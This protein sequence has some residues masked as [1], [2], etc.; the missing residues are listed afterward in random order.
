MAASGH[1]KRIEALAELLELL[2][3]HGVTYYCGHGVELELGVG[4]AM[5]RENKPLAH[6]ERTPESRPTNLY[7]HPSLW[8]DGKKPTFQ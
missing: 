1:T 2:R 7:D 5:P 6:N 4:E 8:K 3:K